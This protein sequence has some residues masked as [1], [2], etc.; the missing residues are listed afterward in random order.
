VIA[1]R[2][3]KRKY[4]SRETLLSGIGAKEYGGRWNRP[5]CAVVYASASPSLALLETL[6]HADAHTM[7]ANIVAVSI[8]IPDDLAH[9]RIP[10]R[11]MHDGWREIGDERC[12]DLG[13][14]WIERG[15]SVVLSVPSAVNPLEE[16]ILL[17][18]AHA[19]I[20]R[21]I[22]GEIVAIEYDVRLARLFN[23]PGRT[24]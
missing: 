4:A 21:C 2:I 20:T 8:A 17:N 5:G 15:V 23:P 11:D 1:W 10:L 13:S 18:P 6:V 19:D 12:V 22:V 9:A 24:G 7:P 14:A 3:C 16:N